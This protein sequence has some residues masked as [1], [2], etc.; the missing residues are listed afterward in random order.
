MMLSIR[1]SWCREVSEG[2]YY[3]SLRQ[4]GHLLFKSAKYLPRHAGLDPAS[5]LLDSGSR[6]NDN[7]GKLLYQNNRPVAFRPPVARSLA[8]TM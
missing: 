8:F 2:P 3:Q 6:R 1:A 4:P 7:A 5:T